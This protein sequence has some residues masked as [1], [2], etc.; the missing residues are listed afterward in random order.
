MIGVIDT[1]RILAYNIGLGLHDVYFAHQIY[2]LL[3]K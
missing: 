1:E 2:E 3:K